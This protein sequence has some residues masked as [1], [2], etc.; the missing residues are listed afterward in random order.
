MPE[1][2]LRRAATDPSSPPAPTPVEADDRVKSAEARRILW[3]A[4]DGRP[5]GIVAISDPVKPEARAAVGELRAAGVDVWLITGD[6]ARTAAAV[7]A[8]VGIAPDRVGGKAVERGVITQA[9]LERMGPQDILQMIFL[10]GFST[11]EHVTDVSGRG[12]G[13]DAVQAT[14]QAV[15]ILAKPVAPDQLLPVIRQQLEV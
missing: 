15:A 7:A 5:G 13:L 9:Q 4:V 6:Q 8:Q 2:V 11:A 1:N 14:A 10:P 12:V 3:I